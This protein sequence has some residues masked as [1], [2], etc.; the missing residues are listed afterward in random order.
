MPKKPT[1]TFGTI[2][3]SKDGKV[4]ADFHR[5]SDDK[6]VQESEAFARF[7]ETYNSSKSGGTLT[8][9]RQLEESGQ[10]FVASEF[11]IEIIIQLTE[12]V[13]RTFTFEMT[14]EEYDS[15]K[16]PSAV[17]RASGERPWRIDQEL[18]DSALVNLIDAKI[19]KHYSKAKGSFLWLVVF[20]TNHYE[21]EH[22]EGGV[23]RTSEALSRA[24]RHLASIDSLVFDK[25]WF[26]NLLTRPVRVWPT[27]A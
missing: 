1:H 5:L 10:D 13:D 2:N 8:V 17:L 25:I 15:G 11:G 20:A 21:T 4:R 19:N 14:Q 24:R 26:T 18:K 27:S 23:L 3:F 7:V 12:L 16:W 6:P 9:V 22:M